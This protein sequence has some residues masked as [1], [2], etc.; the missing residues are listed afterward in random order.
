MARLFCAP[1]GRSTVC[2]LFFHAG[3][4]AVP[5]RIP[6]VV[7]NPIKRQAERAFSHV[8]VKIL[9]RIEPSFTHRNPTIHVILALGAFRRRTTPGLHGFPRRPSATFMH[10][11]RNGRKWRH[12]AQN[13][14]PM[15]AA[16]Y[17]AP[18]LKIR[19]A[20][21]GFVAA[22]AQKARVIYKSTLCWVRDCF[23]LTDVDKAIYACASSNRF[24]VM[25]HAETY[26]ATEPAA[27]SN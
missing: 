24:S 12:S 26:H 7:I 20:H 9:K 19:F 1:H 22:I 23:R 16:G 27:R 18:A 4:A 3:P 21:F 17:V 11:V 14:R 5:R 2:R 10:A 6:G 8:S 25:M 13:G 15:A